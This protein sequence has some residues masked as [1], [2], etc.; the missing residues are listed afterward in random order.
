MKLI[1]TFPSITADYEAARPHLQF[2]HGKAINFEQWDAE[3]S[4]VFDKH[5]K[6]MH[7]AMETL[8][9]TMFA[10]TMKRAESLRFYSDHIGLCPNYISMETG[11]EIEAWRLTAEFIQTLEDL[12]KLGSF[13]M[14]FETDSGE[15]VSGRWW[16]D[17]EEYAL[18]KHNDGE[19]QD[20]YDEKLKAVME[21]YSERWTA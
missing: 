21:Q 13:K 17:D 6:A 8:E 15:I 2:K 3:S 10:V 20:Y 7:E 4:K 16:H 11:F 12:Q 14:H 5:Y 19:A 1:I 9:E 18:Y